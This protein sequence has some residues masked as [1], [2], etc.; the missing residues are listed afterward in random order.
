M[1]KIFLL[2][3]SY[4]LHN[5]PPPPLFS[6][7][8]TMNGAFVDSCPVQASNLGNDPQDQGTILLRNDHFEHA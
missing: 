5:A 2:S 3:H 7:I 4:A 8:F 1:C 6:K